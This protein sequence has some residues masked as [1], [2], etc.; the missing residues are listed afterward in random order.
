[1]RRAIRLAPGD[2]VRITRNGLTADGK[3]RLNNGSL[4]RIDRFDD[5]GN[6]VLENGWTIAK[7]FGASDAWLRGDL[8]CQPGQDG[9]S[10]LCRPVE[11]VISGVVARAVLRLVFQRQGT[12]SP[13]TRMTRTHLREAIDQ[14]DE[15][16]SATEFVNGRPAAG[17]GRVA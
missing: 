12:A 16:V 6:I 8:T 2:V 13:S 1:M 15:R 11:P 10:R 17:H 5:D 7:D 9:R 3:H 4:Y 14:S